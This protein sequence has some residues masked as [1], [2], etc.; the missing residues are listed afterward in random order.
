VI[1]R[2]A[3][4]AVWKESTALQHLITSEIKSIRE[5]QKTLIKQ[6]KI[7]Y[8]TILIILSCII[9]NVILAFVL[10]DYPTL[11]IAASIYLQM[12]YFLTLLI[13]IGGG[14]ARIPKERIRRAFSTLY[15]TGIIPSTDRFTRIM[16]DVFLIN[17]RSLAT[18]FLCIF[19]LDLIFTGLA[20]YSGMFSGTAAAVI[21]FQVLT[22]LTFYLLLLRLEPGTVR[23]RQEITWMKGTLAG[24]MVPSWLT[25]VLFGTASLMGLF[26]I[27]STIIIL[28]GMTIKAFLSLSGLEDLTNL[29]LYIGIIS[30]SQYFIVRFFHS[31][32][33]AKMA[34]HFSEIRILMLETA[35][36]VD[37]MIPAGDDVRVPRLPAVEDAP[38][39]AAN[40]LLES[41]IYRLDLRTFFGA[42]PI[43]LVNPDFSVLFDEKVITVITGFLKR[44]GSTEI[45]KG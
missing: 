26:V 33:S 43:Y 17:S 7:G 6:G 40:A 32:S 45:H 24:G 36:K 44:A 25:A 30:I 5:Q 10:P 41:R 2:S 14:R 8:A 35:S 13:P 31:G 42:F 3:A 16:L 39:T 11:F 19:S 12:I 28:P 34:A 38:I 27:L 18:G 9:T 21:L 20:W 15:Q 37:F 4:G 29:T 1:G 22:I 23:F